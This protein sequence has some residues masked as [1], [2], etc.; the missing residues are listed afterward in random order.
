MKKT[1]VL[2]FVMLCITSAIVAQQPYIPTAENLKNREEFQD[3]KFGVF[4]HWGIYKKMADGNG[5]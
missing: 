3:M 1:F 2:F 5:S 4:I